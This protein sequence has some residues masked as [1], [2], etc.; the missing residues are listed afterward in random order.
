MF[1]QQAS[2]T[3][4]FGGFGLSGRWDGEAEL[5][6]KDG[7]RIQTLESAA[8][9]LDDDGA[10]VGYVSTNTDISERKQAEAAVRQSSR[11]ASLGQVAAGVA[12]EINQ[13]LTYI[14]TMTQATMEDFELDDVDKGRVLHRLTESRKY[15]KRIN[16]IIG[17]LRTFGRGDEGEMSPVDLTTVLD[18]TLLLLGERLRQGNIALERHSE[19]GLPLVRANANQLEQV[20]VNLFQNAS[21]ALAGRREDRRITVAMASLP[22]SDQVQVKVS[23]NGVGIPPEDVEKVFEPFFSTKGVGEGTGL[24][25]AIV[26]GI[27]QAHGG[28]ITCESTLKKGTTFTITLPA[29]GA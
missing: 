14:S 18:N 28:T 27:V 6:R 5:K 21:G 20:F 7:D 16:E 23:D 8:P 22:D 4:S 17:H 12:H 3:P 13:P 11:L 19:G 24:G 10:V 9:M 29:E 25:L 1:L 15:I 26:Y 2:Y